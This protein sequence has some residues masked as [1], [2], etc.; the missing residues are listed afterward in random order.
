MLFGG[1]AVSHGKELQPAESE[2]DR[3][4]LLAGW[5]NIIFNL[6]VQPFFVSAFCSFPFFSEEWCYMAGF[7]SSSILLF[8]SAI[9]CF[10]LYNRKR[11]SALF[12]TEAVCVGVSAVM[13]LMP[14]LADIANLAE[15][16]LL[17]WFLPCYAA[18]FAALAWR[19]AAVFM[20]YKEC[21]ER[22]QRVVHG[23]FAGIMAVIVLG[24]A[25]TAAA[26][27][28]SRWAMINWIKYDAPD[29]RWSLRELRII[30]RRVAEYGK[31]ADINSALA[32]TALTA[33]VPLLCIPFLMNKLNRKVFPRA[34]AV[35]LG[36]IA[37]ACIGVTTRYDI[38][39]A[40]DN[41]SDNIVIYLIL[42]G[43]IVPL[44][45]I[46]PVFCFSRKPL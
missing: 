36:V 38:A 35:V 11:P 15:L 46:M 23:I 20:M 3:R 37:L 31:D 45:A 7:S 43:N 28:I 44:L 4:W 2:R 26:G 10:M 41:F 5:L 6:F 34:A 39:S 8:A 33:G 14:F 29:L 13:L 22:Q 21:R 40:K 27:D 17:R 16:M 9:E 25:L 30:F 24:T 18:I 19:F 42:C 32:I 1:E 12:A